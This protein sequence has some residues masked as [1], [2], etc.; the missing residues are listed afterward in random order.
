M[1]ALQYTQGLYTFYG[2]RQ[3]SLLKVR[4]MSWGGLGDLISSPF[5]RV[6]FRLKSG[7]VVGRALFFDR[8]RREQF[9][10]EDTIPKKV[11]N[12]RDFTPDKVILWGSNLLLADHAAE[13][14]ALKKSAREVIE[15]CDRVDR[16]FDPETPEG[17][18]VLNVR[19]AANRLA[20][21]IARR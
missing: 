2:I 3:Q 19:M 17:F 20:H 13:E 4:S 21:G 12:I 6:V 8:Q 16:V 15:E 18:Y 14:S 5:G 11:V 1:V 7:I 9:G 10:M